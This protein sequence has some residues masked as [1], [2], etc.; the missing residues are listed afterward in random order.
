MGREG[1][2]CITEAGSYSLVPSLPSFFRLREK[3]GKTG[4]EAKGLTGERY[5]DGQSRLEYVYFNHTT[6]YEC[7]NYNT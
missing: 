3:A 6:K 5:I 4:D 1:N 7:S 2:T